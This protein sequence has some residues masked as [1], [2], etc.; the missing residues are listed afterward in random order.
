MYCKSILK[1][2]QI[3]CKHYLEQIIKYFAKSGLPRKP[4]SDHMLKTI[5][6]SKIFATIW[7]KHLIFKPL[8]SIITVERKKTVY[9]KCHYVQRFTH[10]GYKNLI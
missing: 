1:C 4:I 6:F 9:R 5:A 3:F 2:Y 7:C 10:E 8:I